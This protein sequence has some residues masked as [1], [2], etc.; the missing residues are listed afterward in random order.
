MPAEFWPNPSQRA[1]QYAGAFGKEPCRVLGQNVDINVSDE[2]LL[3]HAPGVEVG[4]GAAAAAGGA[5]VVHRGAGGASVVQL[6]RRLS[7]VPSP[8]TGKPYLDG[9]R[10]RLDAKSETALKAFQ[11]DHKLRPTGTLD[12]TSAHALI[13]AVR[14]EEARRRQAQPKAKPSGNGSP[15]P[16]RPPAVKRPNPVQLVAL[17]DE[18][19]RLDA[20][21][22]QAWKAVV[23]YGGARTET[24]HEKEAGDVGLSDVTTILLRIEDKLG[25][26]LAAEREAPVTAAEHHA[27]LAPAHEE[28]PQPATQ[29]KP[30]LESLSDAELRSH[31]DRLDRA[32]DRS[33]AVMIARYARVEKRLG[34]VQ[35]AS[36][37]GGAAVV[38]P[39]V[40]VAKP[41][42]KA[43]LPAS[44]RVRSMQR[45]LNQFAQRYLIG[46]PPLAVDGKKGPATK[47]RIRDVR[48]Y[49][50]YTGTDRLSTTIDR[51]LLQRMKGPRS[52]RR[53]NPAMLARAARRRRLQHKNARRSLA[54]R[55][56]VATFDGHPVAAWLRPHLVW[57]RQHGWEGSVISG[58]R[59]PEHSEHVCMNM[60]G[61]PKCPGKCAGKSSNHSGRVAPHGAV[62]VDPTHAATFR[63]LMQRSPHRPRI[64]N[65]LPNDRNHF[66]ASGW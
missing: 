29:P 28:P 15:L 64:F 33:R 32:L 14:L 38:Q 30:T 1:W 18:F 37:N 57:A 45:L 62:D 34:P 9:P 66:S 65:A 11:T 60:C 5:H 36:A 3:A 2:G 35:P 8:R 6:T 42:V 19:R 41:P 56:G 39:K 25:A 51:Q 13:R 31:I 24:F 61:K 47:R 48:Y 43:T 54:P 10:R 46:M 53:S 4:A 26:L 21:A 59:T 20:Q 12:A 50:G 7:F 49:L 23:A 16:A 58:Y 17:V 27:E 63:A 40:P 44:D 52:T 22:D 55:A